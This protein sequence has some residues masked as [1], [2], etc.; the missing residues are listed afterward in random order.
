MDPIITH[1]LTLPKIISAFQNPTV[2]MH[3]SIESS[4]KLGFMFMVLHTVCWQWFRGSRLQFHFIVP[5]NFDPIRFCSS[6]CITTLC[7]RKRHSFTSSFI[8]LS[9]MCNWSNIGSVTIKQHPTIR[10]IHWWLTATQQILIGWESWKREGKALTEMDIRLV[11]H[12]VIWSDLGYRIAVE[13]VRCRC[14]VS[15][16]KTGPV[17]TVWVFDV[18][19][20]VATIRFRFQP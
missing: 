6:L 7:I 18:M 4:L 20:P 9:P 16:G 3:V 10:E 17:A 12:V 2:K 5:T 11:D 1:F 14:R 15:G 8:Y 19:K 13:I